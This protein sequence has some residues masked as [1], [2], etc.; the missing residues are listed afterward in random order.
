M[1]NLILVGG[2]GHCNSVIDVAE[3]AGFNILG[4]LDQPEMVGKDVLSYKVVGTD[5]NIPDYVGIAEFV[6]TVG[7][8]KS[9]T[10]R[11]TI[12]SK[13]I[14]AGGRLATII[15][16][17]ARV[18]KYATIGKGT[19]VLHKAI[20]NTSVVIGENCIVNTL[21][22]IEHGTTIG[23]FCHISTGA[24]VNGDCRISDGCFIG[25][26][27]VLSQG[28]TLHTNTVIGA[29]SVVLHE[30]K[31]SGVYAGNPIQQIGE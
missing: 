6:I 8:I 5:D 19:V 10:T 15:A 16:P 23:N 22:D 29:G 17:D 4:I 1:R 11:Q 20:V 18:S 27:A 30:I 13:I 9:Y 26:Q 21:A 24:M 3:C 7:Q 14:N 25:S 31:S 2:G 28:V 12:A